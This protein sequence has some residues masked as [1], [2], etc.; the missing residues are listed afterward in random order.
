MDFTQIER[1]AAKGDPLPARPPLEELFCHA[2]LAALYRDYRSGT[3]DPA[4][5]KS[6]KQEIKRAYLDA[7]QQ[8]AQQAACWAQNQEFIRLGGKYVH[9]IRNAVQSRADPLAVAELCLRLY[10]A[11]CGESISSDTL[12]EQMKEE[13]HDQIRTGND[14]Q[15]QPGGG[16]C[17][18]LYDGQKAHPQA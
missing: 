4:H 8:R 1:L 12:I 16:G 18:L 17:C 13:Y 9:E 7:K 11:L 15:L 6:K 10:G 3:V 5:A 14:F 2:L